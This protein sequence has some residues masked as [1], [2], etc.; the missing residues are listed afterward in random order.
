MQLADDRGRPLVT[1]CVPTI[2]RA[3]MLSEA[4]ESVHRQTYPNLEILLLDNA[5][6]GAGRQILQRFADRDARVRILRSETRLPM[7]A[8]FNRGV[9]A[10]RGDYVSFLFDDDLF[11]PTLIE[12]TVGVMDR[13]PAAGFAG[14][15]Y[16]LIDEA[17]DVTSQSGLVAETVVV[18]GRE[19]I[20]DQIGRATMIIASPGTLFR[21]RLLAA[22]PFDESLSVHGGDLVMRLRMAEVA[23]VALIAEPLVSVRIHPQAETARLTA[24]NAFVMRTGMLQRYIAEFARRWPDERTFTRSLQARLSLVHGATLVWD[25]IAL[26]DVEEAEQRRLGLSAVPGGA[27]LAAMLAASERLGLTTSRRRDRLAPLLRR[28]GPVIPTPYA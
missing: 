4:L 20:S 27:H 14:S 7:F 25:W 28:L 26:G 22:F 13:F 1:V 16:A 12:R 10:A 2:G 9:R 11:L 5:S 24:I 21:Q 3:M 6:E 18:P 17:G 23:D 15:N 8:N 19:Y